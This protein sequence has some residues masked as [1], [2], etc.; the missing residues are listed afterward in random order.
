MEHSFLTLNKITSKHGFQIK[1]LHSFTK[2][3]SM[4]K[5]HSS[6]IFVQ[7]TILEMGLQQQ[8]STNTV[9]TKNPHSPS[10]TAMK[11]SSL[12]VILLFHGTAV[13]HTKHSQIASFSPPPIHTPSHQQNTCS[14]LE[15]W[16]FMSLILSCSFW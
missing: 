4:L 16:D 3:H 5:S 6:F 13:S 15:I 8:I 9:T 10:F 2:H 11:D 12:V 7:T 14:S 1:Y